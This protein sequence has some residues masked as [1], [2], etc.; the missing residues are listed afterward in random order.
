MWKVDAQRL[1]LGK[2]LEKQ[3]EKVKLVCVCACMCACSVEDSQIR[4]ET[5]A[6]KVPAR[7]TAGFSTPAYPKWEQFCLPRD[8]WQCLQRSGVVTTEGLLQAPTE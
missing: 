3:R 4:A 8:T 1:N 7:E 2:C 5:K 6:N